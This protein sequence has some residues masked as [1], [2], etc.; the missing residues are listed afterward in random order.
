[1]KVFVVIEC[2]HYS[3]NDL[4]CNTLGVHTSLEKAKEDMLE[5][6]KQTLESANNISNEFVDKI[7]AEVD[8]ME[9]T[10]S[11]F[12]KVVEITERHFVFVEEREVED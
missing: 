9:C 7:S 10:I 2:G 3:V 1:M 11:Y 6:H 8:E 4:M 12:N 5:C